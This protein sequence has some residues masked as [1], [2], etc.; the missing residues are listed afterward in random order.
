MNRS[1]TEVSILGTM[2]HIKYDVT[3]DQES[4]LENSRG[5]TDETS[6]S[7]VIGEV[8]PDCDYENIEYSKNKTLRHEI[9]HAFLIESGLDNAS[10]PV[11]G[12]WAHN[13]EMVDWI[14]RQ[15]PKIQKVY[16]FLGIAE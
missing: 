10:S 4:I 5:Y 6:K 15:F 13:E 8:D 9:V 1:I 7:I 11:D 12:P 3:A 16:E 2:Y 14:A